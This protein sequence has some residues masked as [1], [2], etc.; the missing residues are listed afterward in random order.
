MVDA[1]ESGS[2]NPTTLQKPL[3]RLLRPLVRLLIRSGVTFP[4]ACDLLRELF[5][6]V[7]EHEFALAG[8]SQTDSRVSL[9]TGIHRKEVS[10]LRGAGTPV[11]EVPTALSRTSLIIARW[12]GGPPFSTAKGDPLPLARSSGQGPSFE[13]LVDAVTRDVRSRAVLDEWLDRGLVQLDG[14]QRVVLQQPAFIPKSGDEQ[15]LYYFGRN[16]HDH[17]AAAVENVLSAKPPF[18][19]RAVH[20]DG[21]S[22][23]VALQLRDRSR[24]LA[25]DVL[26]A[27]NL[28]AS[29]ACD[30]DAGG[31][32]RWNFGVYVYAE[33]VETE[34]P[35]ASAKP[36]SGR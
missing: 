18:L 12:I 7:A 32:W 35:D 30:S 19:E 20:Y 31:P 25:T 11:S 6:N 16:V 17:L 36:G 26:K 29:A 24:A 13:A 3:A 8:K 34:A 33:T 10:R 9:L 21:L 27:A 28:E 2:P 23:A 1:H 14:E 4:A 5:V 15:Q 22:R